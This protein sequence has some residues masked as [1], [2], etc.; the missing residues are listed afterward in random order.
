MNLNLSKTGV[1]NA[2]GENA[3]Y[4]MLSNKQSDWGKYTCNSGDY[5]AST[6]RFAPYR[7]TIPIESSKEYVCRIIDNLNIGQAF[8]V[9]V[10]Q[11]DENLVFKNDSGWKVLPYTFTSRD[12]VAYV[13][14]TFRDALN[15]ATNI[16][17]YVDAIGKN[18]LIYFEESSSDLNVTHGFIENSPTVRVFEGHVEANEF[19]EW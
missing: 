2:E 3:K 7:I 5:N 17:S 1:L 14:L 13:R 19:I 15:D 9:G 6:T 16:Q 8:Y 4:N 11:L 12:D 10:H 18:I